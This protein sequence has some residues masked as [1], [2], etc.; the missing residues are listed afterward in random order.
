MS[1]KERILAIRIIEKLRAHPEYAKS[2]GIEV[3][4]VML[5]PGTAQK[6]EK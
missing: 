6:K 1:G 3:R 5:P 4:G 2:L